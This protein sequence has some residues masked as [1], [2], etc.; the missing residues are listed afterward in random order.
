VLTIDTSRIIDSVGKRTLRRLRA[1]LSTPRRV[2]VPEMATALGVSRRYAMR[3][4][5]LLLG[6]SARAWWLVYH[7]DDETPA[8][9]R[10]FDHGFVRKPWQC[11][12]CGA[13]V[14]PGDTL[15]ELEIETAEAVEVLS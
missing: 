4:A 9:R 10:R 2:S 13:M 3:F 15:Y 1:L 5:M 11:E 6:A 12:R 8:M 7:C 14:A